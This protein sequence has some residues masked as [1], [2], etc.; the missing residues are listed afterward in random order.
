MSRRATNPSRMTAPDLVGA[1]LLLGVIAW[2]TRAVI[3]LSEHTSPIL[4]PIRGP[5]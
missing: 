1:V 5:R 3:A 2:V 4:N